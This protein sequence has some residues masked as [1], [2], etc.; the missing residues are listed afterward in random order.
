MLYHMA[1]FLKIPQ[2][3]E[4]SN[5]EYEKCLTEELY[6][7]YLTGLLSKKGY[8]RDTLLIFYIAIL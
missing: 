7:V 6:Y 4:R 5:G 8:S 1:K 3:K 2:M